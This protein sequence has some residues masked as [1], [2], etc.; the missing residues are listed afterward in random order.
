MPKGR[1]TWLAVPPLK[2]V[3]EGR[4][5]RAIGRAGWIAAWA[6]TVSVAAS[7]AL[8]ARPKLPP[9]PALELANTFPGVRQQIDAADAFARAHPN[10]PEANGKLGMNLDAY[11]Q[12]AA[13][14]ICYQRA[15]LLAPSSLQWVYEL[16]YVQMKLGEYTQAAATFQTALKLKPDYLPAKLNMGECLLSAGQ[17][18]ESQK[19]FEAIVG[20]YPENP[21]AYYGLGRAEAQ[22]GDTKGAAAAL[23]RAC[24]LFPQY[25][26]AHYAL[27]LEYR[28]LGEEQ[29]AKEEFLAYQANITTS[30]PA[31]D[32]MRAAVQRL[33]EAP[34]RYLERGVALGES[35]DLEGAIQAHLKAIELDPDLVQPHI[36]LIQL[37]ARVGEPDKAEQ[38]YRIAVRLDPNRSDCYY[39]YGVLMF[40][41]GKYPAAEQAFRKA[42]AINP[43]YAEAHNNLGFL[44]EQQGHARQ[45]LGEFRQAV[46]DRPDY[47]LARFHIG[48]ILADQGDYAGA[49]EQFKKIL[50]PDD[51]S[52][53][54]FLYILGVT[55]ARAGDFPNALAYL[56]KAEAEATARRQTQLAASI[57]H[58]LKAVESDSGG[59]ARP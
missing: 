19:L 43:Y 34:N 13:A 11:Q 39:N 6:L 16:A 51:D 12:Y 8:G 49:V 15:H 50:T 48:Q 30:P 52:T 58:D 54:A 3:S 14:A 24:Q 17:V 47:R 41:Q 35:G 25:G 33:N 46:A 10:D 53:P 27:A 32:P 22:Q 44:L 40:E 42:V 55:Y 59:G 18:S 57:E 37:Y 56:R 23:E 7:N 29:K 2:S 5:V 26:G 28:K 9:L 31:V 38:E 45:A 20:K 4:Y 36:N 21:E 1:L